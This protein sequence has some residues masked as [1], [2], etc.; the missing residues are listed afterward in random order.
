MA[1]VSYSYITQLYILSKRKLNT[2]T[3]KIDY[4]WDFAETEYA[5]W[6]ILSCEGKW[7]WQ[8]TTQQED[9]HERLFV[10]LYFEKEED[11]SNFNEAFPNK[12]YFDDNYE[13]VHIEDRGNDKLKEIELWLIGNCNQHWFFDVTEFG[14]LD[15]HFINKKDAATFKIIWYKK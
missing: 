3:N 9:F 4:Y 14:Q 13:M 2:E 7:E 10:D 11:L 5:G 1:L 8:W 6:L 15:F 12:D